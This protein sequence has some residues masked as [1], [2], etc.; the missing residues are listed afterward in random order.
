MLT[1]LA[2]L[3][4]ALHFHGEREDTSFILALRVSRNGAII[5]LDEILTDHKPHADAF[6]I[7]LGS[8]PQFAEQREQFV[9]LIGFD[10]FTVIDHPNFKHFIARIEG[11]ANL[12]IALETKFE[13]VLRQ[14]D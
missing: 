12:Y 4:F 5:H 8:P 7:H 14:V 6:A 13:R 9:H 1:D 10:A 3:L 11:H 2:L